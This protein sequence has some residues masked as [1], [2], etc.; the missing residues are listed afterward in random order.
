MRLGTLQRLLMKPRICSNSS[1]KYSSSRRR[2]SVLFHRTS[3]RGSG[4]SRPLWVTAESSLC[5]KV[6]IKV[7]SQAMYSTSD[8]PYDSWVD[9]V[10]S[11]ARDIRPHSQNA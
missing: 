4:S 2:R 11:K 8:L 9:Q 6:K 1:S 3:R 10:R 5:V 7:Q